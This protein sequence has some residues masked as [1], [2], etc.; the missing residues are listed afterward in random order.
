[1]PQT[2]NSGQTHTRRLLSKR[3]E[4]Q[5]RFVYGLTSGKGFRYLVI[6]QDKVSSLRY[7][8]EVLSPNTLAE[9]FTPIR[10][11]HFVF[12]FAHIYL[13]RRGRLQGGAPIARIQTS[14]AVV[15]QPSGQ[16]RQKCTPVGRRTQ[17][18]PLQRA[19]RACAGLTLPSSRPTQIAES[20]ALRCKRITKCLPQNLR[21]NPGI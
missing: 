16:D 1:M 15:R 13:A 5:K 8:L 6:Q 7:P 11:T 17:M 14:A 19:P 10:G 21:I 18:R 2:Q 9:I 3:Q 20:Q 4:P 12:S